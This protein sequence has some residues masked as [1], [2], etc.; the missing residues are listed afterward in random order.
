MND[1]ERQRQI[2]EMPDI[3]DVLAQVHRS[4]KSMK[5]SCDILNEKVHKILLKHNP[6][7]EDLGADYTSCCGMCCTCH[8]ERFDTNLNW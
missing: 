1:E 3:A 5:C 4:R 7:Y 8:E 6:N 2:D